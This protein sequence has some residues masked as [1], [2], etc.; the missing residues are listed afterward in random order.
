M[1]KKIEEIKPYIKFHLQHSTGQMIND[2]DIDVLCYKKGILVSMW[3]V[4]D[5]YVL[6]SE[7][8]L[9]TIDEV[10]ENG[11]KAKEE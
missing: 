3:R 7:T 4:G 6:V 1:N 5:G 2:E 11:N 10:L 8:R 9:K